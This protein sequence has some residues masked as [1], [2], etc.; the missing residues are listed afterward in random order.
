MRLMALSH[1]YRGH[2]LKIVANELNTKNMLFNSY[3]FLFAYFPI[4][5]FAFFSIGKISKKYAAIFLGLASLFFYAWTSIKSLPLLLISIIVNYGFG[6]LISNK[7][8]SNGISNQDKYFLEKSNWRISNKYLLVAGLIFNLGLLGFFKYCNFFIDNLNELLIAEHLNKIELLKVALPIGISFFTFTQIAFL[9]DCYQGKVKEKNFTHYLLFVTYFPHLIAGPVLHHAQMMPQFAKQSTYKINYESIALGILI[10]TIG[11]AKKVLLA[12][13]LGEYADPFFQSITAFSS[14]S[15]S[16]SW[17]AT[18]AYT[19]QIY[20]D[21]SG[22]TD[23][24]IGLSLMFGISLPINF[25]APYRSVSIIEFWRRWH[26]SLSTFLR[27]YLYIPLGGNRGGRFR[28]YANLIITMLLGGLW[29]GANWTFVLW[30][31]V[32]GLLLTINHIW[33]SFSFGK[34]SPL[35]VLTPLWWLIVF[36]CICLTW[37]IF[38]VD[39]FYQITPVFKGLLGMNLLNVPQIFE[40]DRIH[41]LLIISFCITLFGVPSHRYQNLFVKI[42]SLTRFLPLPFKYYAGFTLL[43]ALFIYCV[44]QIGSYNPFLYFQF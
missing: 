23:M 6:L 25:N 8:N 14:P 28:R 17:L 37:V 19:F 13:P 31:L 18:L 35:K 39:H 16:D 3:E 27:D 12:N 30:G 38:R 32:H 20:F 43:F 29:H 1:R 2:Y 40:L 36:I 21:F 4:V 33:N 26:I 22:Y 7:V 24:A 41:K 11:L 42:N 9:V 15:F 10:F 5:F 34:I 44:N